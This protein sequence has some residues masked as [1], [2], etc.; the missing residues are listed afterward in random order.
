[1]NSL[2]GRFGLNPS[3]NK[4]LIANKK[5]IEKDLKKTLPYLDDKIDLGNFSL[6]SYQNNKTNIS[7]NVAIASFVTA[8]ARIIMSRFLNKSGY[9][10]FYTDTDSLFTNKPLSPEIIDDKKLVQKV[11]YF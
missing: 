1:M 11:G 3:L 5:D 7:S 8:Y 2:Y 10:V 6:Y 9:E 4:H